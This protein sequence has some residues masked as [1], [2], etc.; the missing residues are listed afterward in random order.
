MSEQ[1]G[2]V[3]LMGH[4]TLA[5]RISEEEHFGAKM[6]RVDVPD[7]A[8]EFATVWF[9]GSSVYSLQ[10]TDEET[11]REAA[12]ATD[13][14][15]PGVYS[16]RNRVLAEVKARLYL[17]GPKAIA[18]KFGCGGGPVVKVDTFEPRDD[19]ADEDEDRGF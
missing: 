8:G 19:P 10:Y 7:E 5:G 4:K 14:Q 3:S 1:W 6:G 9:G 15:P 12:K 11:A 16:L 17:D 2:I 13:V 18:D